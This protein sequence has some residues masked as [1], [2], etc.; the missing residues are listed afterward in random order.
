MTYLLLV[1]F[2]FSLV[3]Q[4]IYLGLSLL[5]LLKPT[6]REVNTTN[7]GISIIIAAHNEITNLKNLIPELLN[8]KHQPFE[9]VIGLDRCTDGSEEW[10]KSIKEIHSNIKYVVVPAN[11]KGGKKV[12]LTKAIE[13]AQ[14]DVLALTDADCLPVTQNWLSTINDQFG[15][16]QSIG[17]GFSPYITRSGFLN[18]F[19]RY[20][21]MVTAFQY[22]SF[23]LLGKPYMGVGR[24]LVFRKSLFQEVNG[25]DNYMHLSSGDDDL[26]V[27][28]HAKSYNTVPILGKDALTI[29]ASKTSFSEYFRQ[30][31]RHL[32]VGKYYSPTDQLLLGLIG[33]SQLMFWL[34]FIILAAIHTNLLYI[35][36]GVGIRWII[37]VSGIRQTTKL[38]G[39]QFTYWLV[40]LL[41]VAY[42]LYLLIMA[43]V[44]FFSK[45]IRWK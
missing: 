12:A 42:T 5:V 33:V 34:T 35:L 43:P 26:F 16:G 28:Q 8:Q 40:P 10:L 39:N 15:S 20:E 37:L 9:I 7:Q 18:L 29:S 27:N 24:N 4:L 2:F 31:Q 14:Y 30:K 38:L 3:I 36:V 21:T 41:D 22:L 1:V 45:R 17:L 32:S 19:I 25:Y 44:G 13:I 6:K 11:S 23:C